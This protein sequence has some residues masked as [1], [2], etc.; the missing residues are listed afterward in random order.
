[1]TSKPKTKEIFKIGE[2]LLLLLLLLWN[3][4]AIKLNFEGV[5]ADFVKILSGIYFVTT[6]FMDENL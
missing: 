1:M 5:R 6:P 4:N 2:I 3:K